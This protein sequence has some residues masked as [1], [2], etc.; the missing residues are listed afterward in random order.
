MNANI[1][2]LKTDVGG[3]VDMEQIIYH[4]LRCGLVHNCEIERAIAFTDRTMIDD[5]N[6]D[7]F[8]MPKS[9]MWGLIAAIEETL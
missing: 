1:S 6:T 7:E 3:H 4:V 5:W 2:N 8:Y 9:L